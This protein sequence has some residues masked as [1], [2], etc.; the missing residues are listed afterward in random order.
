MNS[1]DNK[2][3]DLDTFRKVKIDDFIYEVPNFLIK[4]KL[5]QQSS[6]FII[7]KSLIFTRSV[8]YNKF[9]NTNNLIFPKSRIILENYFN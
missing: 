4:K 3:E 8:L 1:F 6:K 9:F 7:K 2:N 5:P